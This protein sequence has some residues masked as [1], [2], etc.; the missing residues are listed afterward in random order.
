MDVDV[1]ERILNNFLYFDLLI[2]SMRSLGQ[3]LKVLRMY[4][5]V[6]ICLFGDLEELLRS[7]LQ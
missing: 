1:K 4:A 6:L 3:D 7:R 5:K 2:L